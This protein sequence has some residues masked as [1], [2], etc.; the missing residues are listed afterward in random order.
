MGRRIAHS[1]LLR[2][3]L[4]ATTCHGLD[5][6]P[7]PVPRPRRCWE[8][9]GLERHRPRLDAW[10][11][12]PQRRGGRLTEGGRG[13]PWPCA[14]RRCPRRQP[15]HGWIQ[16]CRGCALAAA[17]AWADVPPLPGGGVGC[18][19]G[20][21][22]PIRR[23]PCQPDAHLVRRRRR[24]GWAPLDLAASRPAPPAAGAGGCATGSGGTA[25][26]SARRCPASGQS[27]RRAK[28]A[29]RLPGRARWRL[30]PGGCAP[31]CPSTATVANPLVMR[32]ASAQQWRWPARAPRWAAASRGSAE[33]PD[34]VAAHVSSPAHRVGL[35]ARPA[36]PRTGAA[37]RNHHG[38]QCPDG[39]GGRRAGAHAGDR[40]AIPY[41]RS[42][43]AARSQCH[44]DASGQ[45]PFARR[46]PLARLPAIG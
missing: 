6:K 7:W 34:E 18:G 8:G 22:P 39:R 37:P 5:F 30:P 40:R 20:S 3:L 29:T 44:R 16:P 15:G 1:S 24:A 26:A 31:A 13:G 23:W 42:C 9:P 36:P 43:R 17:A 21:A 46:R 32:P 38:G 2:E 35:G 41:H 28:G 33:Q 25:R 45:A 10:A 19:G 27:R 14:M 12:N 4:A 11:A